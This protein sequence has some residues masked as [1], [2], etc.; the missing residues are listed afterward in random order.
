MWGVG[1]EARKAGKNAIAPCEAGIVFAAMLKEMS[2]LKGR[3]ILWPIDNPSALHTFV[4][5]SSSN[6]VLDRISHLTHM[7]GCR[8]RMYVWWEYVRSASNWSDGGSREGLADTFSAA[9]GFPLEPM[10][11]SPWFWKASLAELWNHSK[12]CGD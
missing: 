11:L 5:G 8:G 4:K 12:Y 1:L 2:A 7:Y 10:S 6:V 3:R 9:N